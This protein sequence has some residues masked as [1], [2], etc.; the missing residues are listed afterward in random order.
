[1]IN[2]DDIFF[3][4]LVVGEIA[5]VITLAY[6]VFFPVMNPFTPTS[7]EVINDSLPVMI[8]KIALIVGIITGYFNLIMNWSCRGRYA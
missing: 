7:K 1:M 2:K 6:F 5:L 8:I 4:G 3:I